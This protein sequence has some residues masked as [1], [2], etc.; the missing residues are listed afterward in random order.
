MRLGGSASCDCLAPFDARGQARF[1]GGT[2][3]LTRGW[4]LLGRGVD[5]KTA[6][7]EISASLRHANESNDEVKTLFSLMPEEDHSKLSLAE[8]RRS[9][10]E[11]LIR[12][13]KLP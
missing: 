1:L 12:R 3:W 6:L 5:M 13:M 4:Y 8:V 7:N 10:R 11:E 9:T 2:S